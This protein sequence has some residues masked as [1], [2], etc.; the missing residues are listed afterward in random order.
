MGGHEHQDQPADDLEDTIET[1][2]RTL[3]RKARSSRFDGAVVD[4]A[5]GTPH[6]CSAALNLDVNQPI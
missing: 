2:E 5:G 3:I 4:A 6:H 1:F